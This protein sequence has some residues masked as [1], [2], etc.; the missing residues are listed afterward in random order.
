VVRIDVTSSQCPGSVVVTLRGELVVT[1]AMPVGHALQAAAV[2]GSQLIVN[3][4]ELTFIDCGIMFVLVSARGEALEAGGELLLATAPQPVTRLLLPT[5]RTG[6]LPVFASAN[7]AT[8]APQLP[9]R[10]RACRQNRRSAHSTQRT[11]EHHWARHGTL[12]RDVRTE[13][14]GRH[15]QHK[16]PAR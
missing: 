7:E 15:G 11:A 4:A 12:P 5:G 10:L 2:Y 14:G 9:Q 16:R 6:L 1:E 3:L 8:M 13:K